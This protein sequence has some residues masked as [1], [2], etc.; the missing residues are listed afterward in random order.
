MR[1]VKIGFIHLH[2]GAYRESIDDYNHALAL[3]PDLLDAIEYRGRHFWASIISTKPRPR[4]WICFSTR[5]PW[6]IR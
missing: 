1:G 4:T 5:A 3:K 6:P 2:F